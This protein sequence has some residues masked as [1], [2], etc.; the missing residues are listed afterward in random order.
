VYIPCCQWNTAR[1][2]PTRRSVLCWSSRY[3]P[4]P[5]NFVLGWRLG[6]MLR[7]GSSGVGKITGQR[8]SASMCHNSCVLLVGMCDR[9]REGVSTRGELT[10]LR[11]TASEAHPSLCPYLLRLIQ[12]IADTQLHLNSPTLFVIG[13]KEIGVWGRFVSQFRSSITLRRWSTE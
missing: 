13:K 8:I 10:I 9:E 7:L 2:A 3:Q 12:C 6:A 11:R 1:S 5:L 4:Q